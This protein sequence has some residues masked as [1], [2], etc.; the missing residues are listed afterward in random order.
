MHSN[1]VFKL[2]KFSASSKFPGREAEYECSHPETS[3]PGRKKQHI[4]LKYPF[5]LSHYSNVLED[6]DLQI[7]QNSPFNSVILVNVVLYSQYTFGC[8]D[9]FTCTGSY[10]LEKYSPLHLSI[11]LQNPIQH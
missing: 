5:F 10:V 9:T 4:P 1:Y 2:F 6:S 3:K 8:P 11:S 7:Q